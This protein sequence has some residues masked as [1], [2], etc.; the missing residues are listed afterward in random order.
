MEDEHS[1]CGAGGECKYLPGKKL[2][3]KVE[4][5]PEVVPPRELLR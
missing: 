2:D 1:E 5:R 4:D 3:E